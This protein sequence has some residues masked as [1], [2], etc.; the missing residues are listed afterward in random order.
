MISIRQLSR[1]SAAAI[2]LGISALVA[3]AAMAVMLLLW[4]PP[5]LFDG[6]GGKELIMLIIGVDVAIGPFL[7]WVVFDPR[8]KELMFDLAVIAVLQL[9]AL[10]YGVYTMHAARPVFIVFV[11]KHFAV[12]SAAEVEDDSL[13]K[14]RPA[15]RTRPENGPLV[16]A[17]EMPEDP[18]EKADLLF[19]GLAGIG[20]Q[21]APQYYVPYEEKI[22][23]V[24]AA[25]QPLARFAGAAPDKAEI[26]KAVSRLQR[27]PDELRF[28]PMGTPK[29]AL[30]ALVD[31]RSGRFLAMVAAD[32]A[33]AR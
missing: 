13:S 32:P 26:D 30:T 20:A 4:Y 29:A 33:P 1:S 10:S 6:M 17:V 9:G 28:V 3:A 14:A 11:D 24:L 19:A 21:H 12:V 22:A 5:P 27:S 16:V 8:K 25:A 31:A 2:H 18:A 15:F 7:T 23:T